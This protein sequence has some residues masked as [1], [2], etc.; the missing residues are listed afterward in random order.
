MTKYKLVKVKTQKKNT[1]ICLPQLTVVYWINWHPLNSVQNV[2]Q[3][4]L[5]SMII[6][7]FQL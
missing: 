4:S 1:A 6:V 2:L 7:I 3:I 5:N